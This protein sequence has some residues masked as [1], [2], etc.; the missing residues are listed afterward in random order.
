MMR[1]L[2]LLLAVC[3]FA[4]QQPLRV[5]FGSCSQ[6]S[7]VQPLWPDIS[8]RTPDLFLW[9]GDIVY[10]DTPIFYKWRRPATLDAIASSLDVTSRDLLEPLMTD[11][12]SRTL[13][14][15]T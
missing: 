12:R 13:A 1:E 8:S 6:T 4:A 11:P 7:R 14:K 10:A 3:A 5:A 9:L 2:F 15:R